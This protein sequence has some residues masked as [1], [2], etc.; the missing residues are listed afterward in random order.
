MAPGSGCRG[1][2]GRPLPPQHPQLLVCFPRLGANLHAKDNERAGRRGS[3]LWGAAEGLGRGAAALRDVAPLWRWL[4]L[5]L[6]FQISQIAWE[7]V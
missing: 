6:R 1:L 7:R 4:Q 3:G 5:N 2:A